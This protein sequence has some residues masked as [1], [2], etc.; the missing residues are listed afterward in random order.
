MKGTLFSADFVRDNSG[1]PRLLELNTDTTI[2]DGIQDNV[3]DYTDFHSVLS[4][5]NITEV[6]VVFKGFHSALVNHM[7]AS[8]AANVA[9]VTTWTETE[10]EHTTVYPTA[11]SDASD[12]F[13]LRMAYDENAL[14]DSTYAKTDFNTYKLFADNSNDASVVQIYHSS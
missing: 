1:N 8:V 5:N 12:K 10:E 14:L 2:I 9:G 11:V 3:L 4:S 13:I 6:H 7:S